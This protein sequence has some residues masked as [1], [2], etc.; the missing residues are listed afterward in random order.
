MSENNLANS[1]IVKEGGKFMNF[2]NIWPWKVT[3][4]DRYILRWFCALAAVLQTSQ[5]NVAVNYVL[6][7]IE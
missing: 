6:K 1:C 7:P 4:R 2:C 5:K 3:Q